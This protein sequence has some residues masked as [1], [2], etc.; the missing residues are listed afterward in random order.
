MKRTLSN[1]SLLTFLFITFT[2]V[3]CKSAD[4]DAMKTQAWEAWEGGEINQAGELAKKL[5]KSKTEAAS[6]QHILF[7]KE[8]IEGHYEEALSIYEKIDHAYPKYSE[9][10]KTV[11][12]AYLHLGRYAEAEEFALSRN[13][14]EHNLTHLKRLKETPL[15]VK[16]DKLTIIPFAKGQLHEWFPDFEAELNGEKIIAYVDTGGSFLHMAPA[17]AEKLGIKLSPYGKGYHGTRRVDM[18]HG[19]AESFRIG[20]ASFRNVPVYAL[21]SLTG[22]E[23]FIIFGTS[24]LKQFLPTLDYPNKRLILSPRNDPQF[25]KEHLAMLPTE[26]VEIPFYLGIDHYMF[27]HG[28]IGDHKP[29]TFFIDSGLVALRPDKTGGLRQAAFTTTAD[30]YEKWGFKQEEIETKWF[31]SPFP[32]SLGPLVQEGHIC[33]PSD[34]LHGP[35]EKVRIDGLL[36]H[37]FLKKYTWTIDFSNRKLIFSSQVQE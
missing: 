19:T 5:V 15:K 11:L 23:N 4:Y 37:A 27:A 14:E 36:S 25:R 28:G 34:K 33:I 32:I 9:L 13:M 7:L 20:D 29:L 6:G 22:Q 31:E 12:N 8:F 10:D 35:F 18:Y 1:F 17:R 21:A 16:L 24:I 2:L 30:N 3:I 26:Q